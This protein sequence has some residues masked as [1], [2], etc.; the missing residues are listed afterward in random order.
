MRKRK[1]DLTVLD[2]A[3]GALDPTEKQEMAMGDR[4]MAAFHFERVS[5]SQSR[6]SMQTPG[7]PDRKYYSTAL[8]MT[9]WWEVKTKTGRAR[10]AQVLF[11]DMCQ[12]CG[13]LY[14]CGTA[15]DLGEWLAARLGPKARR[16][17]GGTIVP[18][19]G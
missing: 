9:F 12:R 11:A 8:G 15:A 10:P 5:F 18:K 13:E 14:V 6:A 2:I 1:R 16:G 7:I 17:V 19:V 3:K 4:L